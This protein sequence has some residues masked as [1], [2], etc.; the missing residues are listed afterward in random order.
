MDV[1]SSAST[2]KPKHTP[3]KLESPPLIPFTSNITSTA[4]V[5]IVGATNINVYHVGS[6]ESQSSA[7]GTS[8]GSIDVGYALE[9]PSSH[10]ITRIKSLQQCASAI[11]ELVYE[12]VGP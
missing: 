5:P 7:P 3:Y 10:C 1:S 11:T 2:S 12:K 6:F 9:Q 4:P 8:P